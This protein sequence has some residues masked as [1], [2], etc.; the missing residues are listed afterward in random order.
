MNDIISVNSQFLQMLEEKPIENNSI[1]S[2]DGQFVH[3]FRP[4]HGQTVDKPWND[5]SRAWN[6]ISRAWAEVPDFSINLI[7]YATANFWIPPPKKGQQFG[8]QLGYS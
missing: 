6:G 8:F 1:Q 7:F 4:D 5:L 2:F 3:N